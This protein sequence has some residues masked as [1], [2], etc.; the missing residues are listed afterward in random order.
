MGSPQLV[1]M[2]HHMWDFNRRPSKPLWILPQLLITLRGKI[3]CIDVMTVHSPLDFNFLL[4]WDYVYAMKVVMST[5]FRVMHFPHNGNI[6]TIDHLSFVGPDLTTKH[7][8]PMNVP[9]MQMLS[10]PPQVNY[11]ASCPMCSTLNEKEPLFVCSTSL[12]LDLLVDIM[13][14][15]IGDL[16]PNLPLVTHTESLDM[17]SFQSVSL[18]SDE[19]LLEA[20]VEGF[21]Q[22]SCFCVK[23]VKKG[24]K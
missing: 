15:S 6:V 10:H 5:L 14:H 11:V 3:V 19:D 16:E 8:T 21:K 18:P 13:N 17:Y 7:L 4:E 24:N 23:L 2:T 12:D 9:Y 1:S 20:M 22:S